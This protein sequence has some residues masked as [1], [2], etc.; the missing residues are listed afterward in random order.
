MSSSH[1]GIVAEFLYLGSRPFKNDDV[2]TRRRIVGIPDANAANSCS[3]PGPF[4]IG[5]LS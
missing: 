1:Q 2:F 4:W 5:P 3:N